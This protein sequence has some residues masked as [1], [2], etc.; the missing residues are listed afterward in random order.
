MS[1]LVQLSANGAPAFFRHCLPDNWL[2]GVLLI[3]VTL[4]IQVLAYVTSLG[5]PAQFTVELLHMSWL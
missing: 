1:L 3:Q 5:F 4:W 2:D